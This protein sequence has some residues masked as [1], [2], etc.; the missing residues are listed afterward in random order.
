M[1]SL[2]SRLR[3]SPE[4]PPA[5]PSPVA[6]GV[7]PGGER[8]AKT[9]TDYLRPAGRVVFWLFVALVLFRGLTTILGGN[10]TATKV[11][12]L[13][14]KVARLATTTTSGWP[15][16]EARVFAIQFARV[17]FTWT[18]GQDVTAHDA[19]D[20]L[21]LTADL[22]GGQADTVA[23]PGKRSVQTYRDGQVIR[24]ERLDPNHALVT[25]AAYVEQVSTAKLKTTTTRKTLYLTIPVARD[26][27]GRVAVY[28][29]PSLTSPRPVGTPDV[30]SVSDIPDP[31]STEIADLATRFVKA[32]TA[33]QSP[34]QLTF[35]LTPGGPQVPPL[36]AT[37]TVQGTP[38][39]K[40]IGDETGPRRT[41][42]VETA[43]KSDDTGAVYL[44]DYR[45]VVVR[46]NR[47]YV[48]S[49]AGSP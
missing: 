4:A 8:P 26:R 31:G 11:Q 47:W 33:G 6:G 12:A 30:L 16:D 44:A 19:A 28:A 29:Y 32:Y 24:T 42:R 39:V 23:I 38:E 45:L 21:F 41:I 1:P 5:A 9:T 48:E 3:K 17:Y 18:P 15:D 13:D 14:A 35:F 36:N 22:R 37:Y 7:E 43:L 49:V 40:Q 2:L 10:A 25:V 27:F 34:A 46:R 20:D